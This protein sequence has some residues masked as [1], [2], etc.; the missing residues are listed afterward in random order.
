MNEPAAAEW[1]PGDPIGYSDV[2]SAAPGE[3]LR[4]M[5][6]TTAATYDAS[7]V[8]LS[9]LGTEFETPVSSSID[10]VY[11]GRHQVARAGS[12][13]R[14]EGADALQRLAS[15]SICIWAWPTR[16]RARAE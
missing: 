14:V 8:R 6:S 2:W 5:V 15:L 12:C 3:T 7:L 11:G 1:A 4:F 13:V 9:G 16:P 10:G